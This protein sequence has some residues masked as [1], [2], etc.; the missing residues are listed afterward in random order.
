MDILNQNTSDFVKGWKIGKIYD[1][2]VRSFWQ[3]SYLDDIVYEIQK[4][5][6]GK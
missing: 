6:E 1:Q 5:I 4:C 2:G 3:E